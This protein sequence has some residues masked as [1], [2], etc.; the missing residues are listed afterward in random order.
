MV[1]FGQTPHVGHVWYMLRVFGYLKHHPKRCIA[2]DSSPINL[3]HIEFYE[4][5]WSKQYEGAAEDFSGKELEKPVLSLEEAYDSTKR[6]R[7][8][9]E[10]CQ[11]VKEWESCQEKR[12]KGKD[13]NDSADLREL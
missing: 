3:D 11:E 9:E 8:I 4:D 10:Y 6:R 7:A 2:F 13:A 1:C 5:D 12:N